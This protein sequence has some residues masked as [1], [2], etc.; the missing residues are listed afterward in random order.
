MQQKGIVALFSRWFTPGKALIGVIGWRQSDAPALDRERRIGHYVV[1]GTQ[2]LTILE[3]G[4]GQCVALQNVGGREVM[5]N[6]VHAGETGGGYV[7]LLPFQGD[8]RS[9]LVRHFQ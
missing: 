9:C 3:L 8:V 7:H 6:H 2:L 5:Q 4:R 1:I